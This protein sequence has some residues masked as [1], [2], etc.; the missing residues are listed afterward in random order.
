MKIITFNIRTNADV[1]LQAFE[2]RLP[3]IAEYLAEE[4]AD[5]VCMQEVKPEMLAALREAFPAHVFFGKGRFADFSNEAVPIMYDPAKVTL[6]EGDTFW[7]SETPDVPGSRYG[8]CYHPRICTWGRFAAPDGA[9]FFVLNTHLDNKDGSAR[10]FG[11]KLAAEK[12]AGQKPGLP[13][14]F[15]GDFNA[16]PDS[17]VVRYLLTE[18]G[19]GLQELTGQFSYTYQGYGEAPTEKI[20]YFFVNAGIAPMAPVRMEERVNEAGTYISDHWPLVL[21]F[22]LLKPVNQ[23]ILNAVIEKAERV[24]PDSLALIGVYGSAATGQE[25]E[26]SDLD[27]MI[28]IKDDAGRKLSAGFILEDSGIGYDIYCTTPESL[29][30]EAELPHAQLSKLLDSQI[31]YVKDARAYQNLLDLREKT[32]AR[33]NS[34]ERITK[35]ADL[36]ARAK[37]AFADACLSDDPGKVR[38]GAFGVIDYALNAAML[39]CGEYFQLGTKRMLE[40][41]AEKAPAAQFSEEIRRIARSKEAAEIRESARSI[42]LTVQDLVHPMGPLRQVTPEI[43]DELRGT[44]EE[45]FSNWRN[46]V[47]EAAENGDAFAAFMNMNCFSEML[48][49]I[50]GGLAVDPIDVMGQ[51]DP[52]CLSN[53]VSLYD[54]CLEQVEELYRKAGMEVVRYRDADD[55]VCHYLGKNSAN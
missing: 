24:C 26:K 16:E 22:H 18:S 23:K 14:I 35:A 49:D 40:E 41:L 44:Y 15:C 6:L 32:R 45:M 51:F 47:E 12:I 43:A 38:S 10:I 9:E 42:L 2:N 53:N 28:L 30:S 8:S 36:V 17:E 31:V 52:D 54:R 5:I 4:Q 50:T 25:Y 37:E 11:A 19:L 29:F 27:L 55:F 39:C 13:V 34:E 33:L 3:L 46:K 21:E 48:S 1:G 20:D 7:I